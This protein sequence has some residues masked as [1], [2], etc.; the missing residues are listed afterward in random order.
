MT[1]PSFW[2]RAR[3]SL[4]RSPH[5]R[6]ATIDLTADGFIFTRRKRE[7]AVRWSDVTQIDGGMRDYFTFDGLYIV[8]HRGSKKLELDELDD[9]FIPFEATLF[10]RWPQIREALNRLQAGKLHEPQYET[11]WRG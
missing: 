11:L 5:R 7:T 10:Q 2:R 9:G 4:T 3:N 6:R 8:V 1:A